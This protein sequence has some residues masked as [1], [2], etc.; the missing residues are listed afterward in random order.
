MDQAVISSEEPKSG[1]IGEPTVD[2]GRGIHEGEKLLARVRRA[3]CLY[4]FLKIVVDDLMIVHGPCVERDISFFFS[5]RFV[6]K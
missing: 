3:S 5:G 4:D 1:G 6:W 2:H